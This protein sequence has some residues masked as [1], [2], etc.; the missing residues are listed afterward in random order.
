MIFKRTHSGV[1]QFGIN[2]LYVFFCDFFNVILMFKSIIDR[3]NQQYWYN[4]IS[5]VD[6]VS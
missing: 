1:L 5:V 2:F 3:A 4:S 6:K